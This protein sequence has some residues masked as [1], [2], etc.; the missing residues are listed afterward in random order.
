MTTIA[1]YKRYIIVFATL[2]LANCGPATETV[3]ADK[4]F[5]GGTILTMDDA[6]GQVEAIAVKDGK[7]I[8]RGTKS[9]ALNYQGSHT[10]LWDLQGK[11]LL[12]GFIDAHSHISFEGLTKGMMVNLSQPPVGTIKTIPE[13]LDRLKERASITPEGEWVVGFGYDD[14]AL[15]EARHP[16]KQELDS[17]STKHNVIIIHISLHMV[18]TNSLR[19]DE[20]GIGPETADPTGGHIA[21]DETG[22]ATGLLLETAAMLAIPGYS[23]PVTV[24]NRRT[25]VEN[26]LKHY[27]SKGI[28]L[29]QEG[30]ALPYMIDDYLA[31]Q[32]AGRLPIRLVV[33]PG[34]IVA[35]AMGAGKYNPVFPDPAMLSRGGAKIIIDGSLQGYTGYLTK[36]YYVQQGS[37]ANYRG[38]S[39]GTKEHIIAMMKELH[40]A[41]WQLYVHVNGDAASDIYLDGLKEIQATNP[42]PDMRSVAIHAQVLRQDQLEDMA[43]LEV[44]PSF[45]NLHTYYWS[46]LHND[47]VLG[48][49]RTAKI[50]AMK[51]AQTLGMTFTMHA[52]TPVTP[53]EPMRMVWSTVTR[54]SSGGNVYG[55]DERIDVLSALKGITI[56]AAHQYFREDSLG[57]I[58]VGKLA[59]FVI[60]EENPLVVDPDHLKDIQVLAT[61]VG[62]KTVYTATVQD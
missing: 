48:P 14:Q 15:M 45:F 41:G 1:S 54:K 62:G 20:T 4:I 3:E 60:L 13:L 52:D 55:A 6:L 30:Y 21:R 53:M 43:E 59:D 29:G 57:S 38:Q 23:P 12:P 44:I 40:G 26:A 37:D 16:T 8:M 22:R 39:R 49:E 50:S 5:F 7:I 11:T 33:L 2:V 19:L 25:Y 24:G 35:Q 31:L 42:R 32:K 10:K 27:A 17:V 9:A 61:L 51:T 18:V 36:P 47:K 56:N 28:T 58:S 34:D 46:D